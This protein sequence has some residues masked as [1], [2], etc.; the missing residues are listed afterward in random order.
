M[1]LIK[2]A[3]VGVI[4]ALAGSLAVMAP[5]VIAQEHGAA[6]EGEHAAGGHHLKEPA[7]GWSFEG[8]FGDHDRGA[9]QR[10]YK[11]YKEVCASCHGMKLLSFR[12]LGQKGGP[13][14]DE[15]YPN[16]NDN[17]A[18]KKIAA[19]YLIPEMD[20]DTGDMNDVPRTPKDAFPSPYANVG[21]ARGSNGGA[22][23]PDLS[24]ITKARHGGASY[25]YSLLTGFVEP[26]QGLTVNPGQHYNAYFS[27]GDTKPNWT[28]DPRNAPPGGFLAMSPPLITDGQVEYEDG[29]E[30][31][32]DQMA[33]DVATFLDWAGD[34]K[35]G[36]RKQLG[37]SV[38][39]Y[40]ILAAIVVYASYRHIWRK[41]EH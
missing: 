2:L 25:V 17:P 14:Y 36:A 41:V 7:G 11:V 28:G 13:F 21:A 15:Q 12:N 3:T 1:R 4:S 29:T 6:A 8:P 20:Q 18:V 40:L 10:G 24:V 26:P 32:I 31:T 37:F 22:I 38:L 39:A 34:P 35:A 33:Q 23:P 27:G 16:P 5:T 30:A 9:L 19:E